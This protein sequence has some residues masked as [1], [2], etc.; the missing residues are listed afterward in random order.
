MSSQGTPGVHCTPGVLS[1]AAPLAARRGGVT[2]V[3]AGAVDVGS[4]SARLSVRDGEP[5]VDVLGIDDLVDHG[6]DEVLR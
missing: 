4:A 2:V 3:V 6:H 1:F 5:G